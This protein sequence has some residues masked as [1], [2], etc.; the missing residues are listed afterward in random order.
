M[1]I[2]NW[3]SR[4]LRALVRREVLEAEM[5]DELRLHFEM[6]VAAGMRQ[7]LSNEQAEAQ[8]RHLFGGM[9]QVKEIYR[10]ARGVR[11]I[12]ELVRDLRYGFRALWR[13]PGFSIIVLLT[14]TLGIGANSAI[15]SVVRGVLLRALP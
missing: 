1:S 7:G 15:F 12:E 2:I 4:R 11:V 6:A 3:A 10:D 13:S 14:L 8:T 5:N 9:E